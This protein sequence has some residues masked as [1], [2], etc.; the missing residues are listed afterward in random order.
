MKN[1]RFL[2][3]F[4]IAVLPFLAGCAAMST[5]LRYKDLSVQASPAETV[6]RKPLPASQKTVWI[7]LSDTSGMDVKLS[8]LHGLLMEKGYAV[9]QDPEKANIWFQANVRYLGDASTPAIKESMHAAYGGPVAGAVTGAIIGGV[10][11]NRPGAPYAGAG[12]G[13]L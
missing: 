5:A 6:F 11:S 13:G 9:V 3:V 7:E 10:S 4:A 12:V 1:V 2:S 8:N